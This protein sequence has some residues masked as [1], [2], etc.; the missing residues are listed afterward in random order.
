MAE[1]VETSDSSPYMFPL[2]KDKI[3]ECICE[4]CSVYESQLKELIEELESARIIIDIQQRELNKTATTENTCSR[5]SVTIQEAPKQTST[6]EWSTVKSKNNT[7]KLTKGN[8]C[9]S[10][11]MEQ[12]IQTTNRFTILHNL[13]AN[14]A[15]L[16]GLQT[17]QCQERQTEQKS[18]Q[19]MNK[20]TKQH[21]IGIKIPT[22]INGRLTHSND[23][24]PTTKKKEKTKA[25]RTRI[26]HKVRIL[27]DS[28]LRGTATKTDQYLNTKF[29]VG[30]W[31]KPG[32]NTKE[33]VNTLISDLRCLG[34]Q[35]VIVINGGSNDIGSK[36]N[37]V[38][39]VSVQMTQF[40]QKN[41]HSNIVIVN[42][43]PRHD[44]DRH[45]VTNLEIQAANR[46]LN[47]I[48]NEYNNVTTIDTDLHRKYFTRHG[49]HLNKLGKEWLSKQIAT[50]INRFVESKSKDASK[51]PLK[52]KIEP[53]DKQ[54][55]ANTLIEQ[56]AECPINATRNRQENSSAT[57]LLTN[58]AP[59][60]NRRL[61]VTRSN[62]FL[63]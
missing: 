56:K 58:R 31:I 57:D 52:W 34:T 46:Q 50:Q 17:L 15:G 61:P 24:K 27:G 63:W 23:W 29:E 44:M 28:H 48:A 49:M 42:I 10:T 13:Q 43:P 14:N 55:A 20:S 51:I 1:R 54:N 47:K 33:I 30:S 35:D 53:I 39:R 19:S 4:R 37:Q 26:N 22:I 45:S 41:N 9:E 40:I 59:N 2:I 32:A 3:S 18:T 16:N 5:D 62:D 36:R 7:A 21:K 11:R 6:K 38:R 12:H 60:R 8:I 25:P